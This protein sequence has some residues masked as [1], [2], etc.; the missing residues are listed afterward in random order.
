MELVNHSPAAADVRVAS[1]EGTPFRHGILIAK[2]TFEVGADGGVRVDTQRPYPLLTEDQATPLGILPNDTVPRRDR[3]LEVIVLGSAYGNGRSQIVVE[4][5]V[6]DHSKRLLVSGDRVWISGGLGARI[7]RPAAFDTI[8]M[9][10]ERAFGGT[11]ECWLD[12][13]SPYDLEHPMNR[14]GR[15]FDAEKLATDLGK[16]LRAPAGYPRLPAD[17][18]R[19]LP[20][21]EDPA[22]PIERWT[23]EPWPCCWATMPMDI[24]A[25]VQRAYERVRDGDPMSSREMLQEVYH[26]AHPDWV[27]P[28]PPAGA[29]VVLRGMTPQGVWSFRLPRTRVLADYELGARTGVRELD[30]H[31]LML[32]PE[33]SRFYLVYRHYFTMQA[34]PD[35]S[36]SFR[37]RLAEGWVS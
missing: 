22:R 18:V 36:R 11:C 7:S 12:E 17:Y 10:W 25:F 6:G 5:S 37:L 4:L 31:V 13:H 14:Y 19:P 34:T 23:D 27:V 3:A 32:L 28:I 29:P 24:G 26:R 33:E 35:M 21:I 8:P 16:S 20:N 9:T 2:L 30:P 15:G 1:V